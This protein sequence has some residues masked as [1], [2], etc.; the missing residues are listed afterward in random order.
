MNDNV[1]EEGLNRLFETPASETTETQE[2]PN[3]E[4][5]ESTQEETA[6]QSDQPESK[7]TP[8]KT[9]ETKSNPMRELRN[10]YNELKKQ[11]ESIRS[12]SDKYQALLKR[13]ADSQ[14]VTIDQLEAKLQE[15]EDARIAQ[16]KQIPVETQRQL[17]EAE[18]RIRQLEEANI[19]NNFNLRAERLQREF[20]LTPEQMQAFAQQAYASGIDILNSNVDLNILYRAFNYETIIN[21]I[22]EQ[23]KQRVLQEINK[24]KQQSPEVGT[25]RGTA[26]KQSAQSNPVSD[27]EFLR[28]IFQQFK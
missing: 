11:L 5:V 1:F 4:T 21:D 25:V 16:T 12:E 14:G 15:E 22:R 23:E 7:E 24:N 18:E 8:A 28:G 26:S 2:V 20:Q 27:A 17:R 9:G 6:T 10:Q 3:E 13:I 19:R